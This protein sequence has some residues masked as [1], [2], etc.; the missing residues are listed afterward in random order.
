MRLDLRDPA[1]LAV[2]RPLLDDAPALAARTS[3]R[4]VEAVLRRI[5]HRTAP[6]S[7]RSPPVDDD[8][9]GRLRLGARRHEVRRRRQAHQG[10]TAALVEATA[11]TGGPYERRALRLSG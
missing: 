3:A 2:A 10:R 6:S 5:A 1:N 11:R 8:S 4:A 9:C 7:A